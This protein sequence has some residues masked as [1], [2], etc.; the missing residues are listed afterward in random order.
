MKSQVLN[1]Q[2]YKVI[3]NFINLY[4]LIFSNV[5]KNEKSFNII[6][7]NL[8]TYL[9]NINSILMALS[10]NFVLF[11]TEAMYRV[12]GTTETN[13]FNDPDKHWEKKYKI[14]CN[15]KPRN[16]VCYKWINYEI[17]TGTVICLDSAVNIKN[18]VIGKSGS[19]PLPAVDGYDTDN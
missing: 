7:A 17:R 3:N 14:L 6:T 15:Y 13:R 1:F 19:V 16:K 11:N 12:F 2:I 18:S 9:I 8:L 10:L 4:S 5:N